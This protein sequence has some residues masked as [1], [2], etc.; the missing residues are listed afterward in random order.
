[1]SA[2]Q[3]S[4]IYAANTIQVRIATLKKI[5]NEAWGLESLDIT[6]LAK[7][8]R[9]LFQIAVSDNPGIAEQLLDQVHNHAEEASEVPIKR[10][11]KASIQTDNYQSEQPYPSEELE[12]ISA[13]AFNHAIDLYCTG[14][15]EGCKNWADR[16]L[17]IAHHVNDG[18]SLERLL[19]N[20]L[21]GLKFDS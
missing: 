18:G 15:D 9:C 21:L 6:K 8:M 20:K 10:I 14:D 16:A 17:N 19:Q 12:W 1:M 7:Y 5:I 13:R 4:Y 3:R 2:V 11:F